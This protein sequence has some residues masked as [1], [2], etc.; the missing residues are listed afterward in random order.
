MAIESEKISSG[1]HGLPPPPP[2]P[3]LQIII[4]ITIIIITII[5]ISYTR[6]FKCDR[7]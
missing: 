5:H 6:W 2:P 7:D 1:Y 4:I 3:P